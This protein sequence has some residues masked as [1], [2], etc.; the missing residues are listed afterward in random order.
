MLHNAKVRTDLSG[1]SELAPIST[2]VFQI[3]EILVIHTNLVM[4]LVQPQVR[5]Y[6]HTMSIASNPKALAAITI[7]DLVYNSSCR[8]EDLNIDVS[9]QSWRQMNTQ[10]TGKTRII[11][12]FG[13]ELQPFSSEENFYE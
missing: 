10:K 4:M 12:I 13:G 7:E 3:L 6:I 2:L 8:E 9:A 1:K 11:T 5:R